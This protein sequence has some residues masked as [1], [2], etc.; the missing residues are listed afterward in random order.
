MGAWIIRIVGLASAALVAF[1]APVGAQ[2]VNARVATG[3][4]LAKSNQKPLGHAM[5]S[6]QPLGRQTFTDDQ[7][8]FAFVAIP[9]GSYRIRATHIGFAPAE[10]TVTVSPDSAATRVRIELEQVQLRLATVRVTAAAR[11]TLPGAPDPVIDHDFHVVF[12]Q[13]ELNAQ[14]YR[15]LADSFPY[16]YSEQHTTYSV[17]TDSSI[18]ERKVDT[19]LLRSDK[20][21]WTY[22]AGQVLVSEKTQ[23]LMHLP[24]LSDF[25]S[26]EFLRNHCF[27][28]GGELSTLEGPAVRIDFRAVDTLRS[29]DVNGTILLDASS[30]QIR[31][32][33]L[34]LSRIPDG[35]SRYVSLVSATTLFREREPSV[36][37][38]SRVHG[39]WTL[40]PPKLD[41]IGTAETVDDQTLLTFGFV[42]TA[43]GRSVRKTTP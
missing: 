37:I 28:Y 39:V 42:G 15:L 7:G 5:V 36:L 20:P 16:A 22:Q 29:P 13:L 2:G 17:M 21:T 24:G 10:M 1:G 26:D 34:Q 25:A 27:R 32:A 43:P 41:I 3:V 23:G 38:I 33:E 8:R 14:Q 18:R 31:S 4:V 11:C 40:F 35:L 9:P 19:L 6:L 30:Y 12:Q